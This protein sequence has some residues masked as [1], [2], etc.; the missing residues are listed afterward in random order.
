MHVGEY[1]WR[2]PVHARLPG[3]ARVEDNTV[4]IFTPKNMQRFHCITPRVALDPLRRCEGLGLTPPLVL[5][6]YP[7]QGWKH[8]L[9]VR[10]A[11]PSYPAC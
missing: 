1:A 10:A 8:F 11:E 2:W 6:K 7:T 3:V 5:F 4:R 9:T